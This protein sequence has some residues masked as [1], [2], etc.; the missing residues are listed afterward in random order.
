M[1]GEK[2]MK[3]RIILYLIFGFGVLWHAIPATSSI[4]LALTPAALLISY[5]IILYHEIKNSNKKLLIWIG[6]V[7]IITFIIEAAAVITGLIF[8][9]YSYGNTLGLM[10]FNVPVVIGLNWAIIIWGCTELTIKLKMHIAIKAAV[11]AAVAVMLDFLIE[12]VAVSLD[13]WR[14]S[15]G[16]IPLQ[17]YIA[18]FVIAYLFSFSYNYLKL[19]SSTDLPVHFF[20]AQVMFFGLLNIVKV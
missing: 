15:E 12:P 4:V 3:W 10:A 8:G 17:N 19:R 7:Y 20:F 13:Y 6:A 11:A 5:I 18:W 1:E 9:E 16:I 2:S 14:W